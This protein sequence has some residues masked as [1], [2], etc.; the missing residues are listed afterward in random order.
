VGLRLA[1]ST[2][3]PRPGQIQRA[4]QAAGDGANLAAPLN[5]ISLFQVM[6]TE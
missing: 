1:R 3:R 6:Y 4:I 2:H 5:E